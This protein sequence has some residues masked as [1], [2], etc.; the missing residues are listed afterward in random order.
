[1]VVGRAGGRSPGS[2][3]LP[4]SPARSGCARASQACSTVWCWKASTRTQSL[5]ITPFPRAGCQATWEPGRETIETVEGAL[6]AERRG[7]PGAFVAAARQAPW[8]ELQVAYFAGEAN[9]TYFVA[10]FLFTRGDF[11]NSR[12]GPGGGRQVWRTLLIT[13]PDTLVAHTQQQTCYFD[14]AGLLR[15]FDY[16]LDALGGCAAVHYPSRYREFDGIKVPDASPGVRPRHRRLS[17]LEFGPGSPSTSPMS[18]SVE[19]PVNVRGASEAGEMPGWAAPGPVTPTGATAAACG[20]P[21][22][23]HRIGTRGGPN[24]QSADERRPCDEAGWTA[25]PMTFEV[26]T[27]PSPMLYRATLDLRA[28]GSTSTSSP[29]RTRA[30][31]SSLRRDR[32]PRSSSRRGHDDHVARFAVGHGPGRRGHRDRARRPGP[33]GRRRRR[34]AHRNPA[35]AAWHRPA[36]PLLFSGRPSPTRTGQL[37]AAGGDRALFRAGV[38]GADRPTLLPKAGTRRP[39]RR[40]RRR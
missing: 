14:D 31:C 35:R 12:A 29:A 8:D 17:D 22:G 6:V 20:R 32:P 16:A 1:M 34:S 24:E 5:T 40:R 18:R 27:L 25:V 36:A 28:G 7:P 9:W 4:R 15:R 33:P 11:V 38:T 26:T 21:W 2:A 3:P 10:P 13:C 23:S 30:V 19:F 37:A 39:G